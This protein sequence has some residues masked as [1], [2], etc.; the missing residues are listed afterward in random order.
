MTYIDFSKLI[1]K[2]EDI[3]VVIYHANCDDGFGAAFSANQF[4]TRQFPDKKIKYIPMSYTTEIPFSE[5]IDKNVCVFDYSFKS[6]ITTQIIGISKKFAVIDHH[7]SAVNELEHI[8]DEYK[9]FNMEYS[10]AYMAWKF[11]FPDGPVPKLI[12]YIQDN[13]IWTKQMPLTLEYSA[14]MPS[15]AHTFNEYK[16]LSNDDE[17]M[18]C[19]EVNGSIMLKQNDIM[20]KSIIEHASPIFITIKNKHY[21]VAHI[22]SNVFR[23]EIGNQVLN[24]L[25]HCNFSAVYSVNSFN[26]TTGFSLRSMNDRTDVTTIAQLYGGGGHR[27]ACGLSINSPVSSLPGT[28]HDRHDTYYNLKNIYFNKY[29]GMNIVYM[30]TNSNKRIIGEYLLQIRHIVNGVP[31]QECI[32]IQKIEND[33]QNNACINITHCDMSII[34]HYDGKHDVTSFTIKFNDDV[35]SDTRQKIINEMQNEKS[36]VENIKPSKY[37]HM[38]SGLKHTL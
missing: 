28:I 1:L 9:V 7:K 29:H 26:D 16:R 25:I 37:I 35:C 13:D 10:G 23:S 22:N 8:S 5:F 11:F 38:F 18:K 36:Y 17:L 2:K 30:N 27:N 24:K 32:N 21:I 14:Y 34:W 15:I 31:I 4:L 6:H 19:I 33:V 3:D 20:I 12:Q